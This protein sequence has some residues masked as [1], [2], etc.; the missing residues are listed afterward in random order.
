MKKPQGD[1]S[2]PASVANIN[3]RR[4][5]VFVAVARTGSMSTAAQELGQTQPAVSQSIAKLEAE[6]GLALFDR[7]IRPPVLTMRGTMLLEHATA[8]I[9]SLRRL[10]AC[11]L[12]G[13]ASQ[14]PVLRI[15]MLNS[16]A[17]SLGP[18]IIRQLQHTAAQWH[19]DTGFDA[20]RV[21]SLLDR[22][23][24]FVITAD[25]SAMP[26]GLTALPLFSEPYLALL[27]AG[28]DTAPPALA[29]AVA[30]LGMIRFGRDPNLLSRMDRWMGEAHIV[31]QQRYYVDT[32]EAV[33]EMVESGMG[34]SLLPALS[35]VRM[36]QRGAAV[37]AVR[38]PG[39]PLRRTIS[40]VARSGEGVTIA[41]RIRHVAAELLAETFLPAVHQHLPQIAREVRLLVSTR[42]H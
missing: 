11:L 31:P 39:T 7:S 21:V 12:L 1:T 17:I 3:L 24:D 22:R 41:E 37:R 27:P 5:E 36:L 23:H 25:E 16:L 13:E 20:A 19:L 35:V 42:R 30:D 10:Q 33:L 32:L 34:W 26:P 28:P 8:V 40:V 6:T 18:A 38:L 2:A 29:E 9:E 4:L 14:L 15:G